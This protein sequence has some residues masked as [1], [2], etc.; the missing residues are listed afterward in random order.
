MIQ[1]T[2]LYKTFDKV[3]ILNGLDLAI[4]DG[5]TKVVIGRSGAGKSVLLKC[6]V[7]ILSPDS[8]S[9]RVGGT[10]LIGL[11]E[12]EYDKVRKN[13]G[14]VFQGGALF[15]S[16]NVG[17]NV[18]FFLDEFTTLPAGEKRERTAHALSLVGLRDIERLMPAQLSGGMKKRV[19]LARILCMEPKI[20]L[21]DEPTSEV[22]PITAD[23]INNLIIEM[24]DKLK[25]TS[26][27]VTHD[28]NAAFKV[29]DSVAMFYHGQVIAD[30]TPEEIRNS[31][32]PVVKQFIHG[33]AHGP[34]T[35]DESMKFGHVR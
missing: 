6:I 33:Q 24:R 7:G 1:I 17:E 5:E 27:V 29:A 16:L 4:R 11:R 32:H 28:M 21:Y 10:E 13:I 31:R 30:G 35:E 3:Q 2:N 19:S 34:V 9:I 25:V 18:G 23:A 26:I 20:I 12:L 8:G 14:Y 22:D 15:D